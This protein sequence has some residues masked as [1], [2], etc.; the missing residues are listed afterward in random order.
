MYN[1][2]TYTLL[3]C[4]GLLNTTGGP[5]CSFYDPAIN[6]CVLLSLEADDIDYYEN[7]EKA[8]K[9]KVYKMPYREACDDFAKRNFKRYLSAEERDIVDRYE[10]NGGFFAYLRETGMIERFEETKNI[11]ANDW[12]H[13][14]EKACNRSI[15]IAAL[16]I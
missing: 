1:M 9:T 10:G 3:E 5:Y 11:A 8:N 16:T 4:K 12:L 6:N 2:N 13:R 14:I 15:D 7:Y